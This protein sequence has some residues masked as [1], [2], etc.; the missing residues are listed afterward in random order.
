MVRSPLH[1]LLI[2]SY[3]LSDFLFL[4]PFVCRF[5]VHTEPG[6]GS[7]GNRHRGHETRLFPARENPCVLAGTRRYMA[8]L[9]G[10]DWV[11]GVPFR[12]L[13]VHVL[14]HFR[15]DV[16]KVV[17]FVGVGANRVWHNNNIWQS[18]CLLDDVVFDYTDEVFLSHFV[19]LLEYLEEDTERCGNGSIS[20][21]I[22]RV[23]HLIARQ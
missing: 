6:W 11:T 19:V 12:G 5:P 22:T 10:T 16:A 3:I 9:Y 2:I 18:S 7:R 13:G 1:S 23:R 17:F 21:N 15:G 20:Q 14:K 4:S 8:L